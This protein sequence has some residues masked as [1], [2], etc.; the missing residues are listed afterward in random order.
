MARAGITFVDV[1]KAAETIRASG[2]DPT[3]DRV[4]EH[5]KT[6]SKSTI[7]PLLKRWRLEEGDIQDTHGLPSDLLEVVKSLYERTQQ[8]AEVRIEEARREFQAAKDQLSKDQVEAHSAISQL[9]ARQQD[10]V[11]QNQH[12]AEEKLFLTKCLEDVRL[13]LAKTE[14]Q[15]DMGLARVADLAAAVGE[16][17]QENRDI[18]SHFEHYQ[19]R[20]AED[21]QQERE[22]F[23]SSQRQLHDQ[24]QT[25]TNQMTT[26]ESRVLQLQKANEELRATVDEQK[27]T[28]QAIRIELAGKNVDMQRLNE[29]LSGSLKTCSDLYLQVEQLRNKTI[30]Q[31]SQ[32]AQS[33]TQIALLSQALKKIE[34]DLK[35]ANDRVGLLTDE[36][37]I[38]LQE[39]AVLQGQLTQL[40]SSL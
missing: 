5:L 16:L 1:V 29:Q 22:Q 30:E 34:T 28:E 8:M 39:K 13:N 18:R 27:L 35:A 10:L 37:R 21:R 6:G 7:A 19:E 9:T 11:Q 33:E 20:I 4:R 26:A 2:Q 36:N 12:L 25:I 38:A 3:V 17:K 14:S 32:M 31:S 23:R 40:Q 24:L 15:R